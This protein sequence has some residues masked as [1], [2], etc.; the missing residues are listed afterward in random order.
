MARVKVK[1]VRLGMSK[2]V[3]SGPCNSLL[4]VRRVDNRRALRIRPSKQEQTRKQPTFDFPTVDVN[5]LRNRCISGYL[6][7]P[8][9]YI[10]MEEP[11]IRRWKRQV[12]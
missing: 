1:E 5:P 8:C 9:S 10:R 3:I 4:V 6:A 12:R 11:P 2:T 7:R